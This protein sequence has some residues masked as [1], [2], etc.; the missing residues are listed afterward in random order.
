MS[1]DTPQQDLVWVS[2]EDYESS[3]EGDKESVMM[4]E[5]EEHIDLPGGVDLPAILIENGKSV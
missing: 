3:V 2:P 4:E 1:G 5:G